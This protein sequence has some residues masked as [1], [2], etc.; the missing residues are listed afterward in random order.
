M[1]IAVLPIIII[2]C[3]DV[4]RPPF[5]HMVALCLIHS[6]TTSW[7]NHGNSWVTILDLSVLS[8]RILLRCFLHLLVVAL[9]ALAKSGPSPDNFA[10]VDSSP[11]SSDSSSSFVASPASLLL[12]VV[13]RTCSFEQRAF[14]SG[15]TF[16][17]CLGLI[18]YKL[19]LRCYT[20]LAVP[21]LFDPPLLL[22]PSLG[23]S[24]PQAS[25]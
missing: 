14:S 25:V 22:C 24:S 8:G 1:P 23:P 19:L 10:N 20:L 16:F 3:D 6:A 21:P 12:V 4:F 17:C 13:V 9:S 18:I 7:A 11:C 15:I 5:A 2:D